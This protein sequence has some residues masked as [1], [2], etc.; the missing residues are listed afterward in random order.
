MATQLEQIK[1]LKEEEEEGK[2]RQWESEILE[3]YPSYGKFFGNII[4]CWLFEHIM[5]MQQTDK[6]NMACCIGKLRLL[7][8]TIQYWLLLL[9]GAK[10]NLERE[11]CSITV[12]SVMRVL[13]HREQI[14]EEYHRY[15]R[16][17]GKAL[18]IL[19]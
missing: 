10:G 11:D 4:C 9:Y 8:A 1:Q 3:K 7:M 18:A 5:M 19:W 12:Y 16:K 14:M 13:D 6:E 2:I 15:W 17:Y